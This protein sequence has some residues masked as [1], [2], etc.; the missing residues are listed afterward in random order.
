MKEY[1]YIVEKTSEGYEVYI[2]S[3]S[4]FGTEY[5]GTYNNYEEVLEV[6]D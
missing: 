3:L 2:R 1:E 5:I 6:I 4:F